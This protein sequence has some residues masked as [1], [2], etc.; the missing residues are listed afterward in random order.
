MKVA[1]FLDS[2]KAEDW[3]SS[4]RRGE[5]LAARSPLS[6]GTEAVTRRVCSRVLEGKVEQA[7]RLMEVEESENG[8]VLEGLALLVKLRLQD[9]QSLAAELEPAS[10][11]E[12]G[13][14]TALIR[15]ALELEVATKF[16]EALAHY[17]EA[18]DL[19]PWNLLLLHRIAYVLHRAYR[20]DELAV[21]Y[22]EQVYPNLQ[23]PA[24]SRETRIERVSVKRAVSL[25]FFGRGGADFLT[26]LL[27]GHPRMIGPFRGIHHLG[28]IYDNGGLRCA[29]TLCAM[30]AM[31][32][33]NLANLEMLF[34]GRQAWHEL[35]P[36]R[37]DPRMS[38]ARSEF[39]AALWHV[40]K[41]RGW[42]LNGPLTEKQCVTAVCLAYMMAKGLDVHNGEVVLLFH[43]HHRLA[44]REGF[45]RRAFED[46]R[47]LVA[48]RNPY[49]TL[50][51]HFVSKIEDKGGFFD[52]AHCVSRFTFCND[53]TTEYYERQYRDTCAGVRLE[54]LKDRPGPALEAVCE[55]LGL[56]WDP[57]L[58]ESTIAGQPFATSTC[59]GATI[60]GF[61][62]SAIGRDYGRYFSPFDRLRIELL[63]ADA[64]STW[65]YDRPRW[66]RSVTGKAVFL[67]TLGYPFRMEWRQ[68]KAARARGRSVQRVVG[69]AIHEY[70]AIRRLLLKDHWMGYKK[71]LHIV[72]WLAPKR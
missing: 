5:T 29:R 31:P 55:F 28:Y 30:I 23:F 66:H 20:N 60:S 27:D 6:A 39:V 41:S 7:L 25:F 11:A 33:H 10:S 18:F 63:T 56:A 71:N 16:D 12:S 40:L 44:P 13:S 45:I 58:L 68:V 59:E 34:D 47:V 65:G 43:A 22:R 42:G 46:L 14:F 19:Q 51:S 3:P 48:V 26:S 52:P 2:E 67:L 17:R 50:A 35:H 21:F 4:Q 8:I 69:D 72:R 37:S 38:V 62:R 61:D 1:S 57:C 32:F 70:V 49:E 15:K 36:E 64:A 24:W 53:L 54:D 9:P